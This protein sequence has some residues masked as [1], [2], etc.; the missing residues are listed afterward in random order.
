MKTV[1][2]SKVDLWLVCLVD[3][4]MVIPAVYALLDSDPAGFIVIAVMW[5]FVNAVLFGIRYIVENDT[6]TVKVAGIRSGR[7]DLKTLQSVR[8]TNTFI[9]GPAASTDRIRM[10]FCKRKSAVI[11]P[12]DRESFIELL[13]KINPE[14]DINLN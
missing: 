5:I 2:N 3:G 14:A 12:A 9:S 8:K 10:D 6:L 7:Y 4:V 11:S 13:K 1:F